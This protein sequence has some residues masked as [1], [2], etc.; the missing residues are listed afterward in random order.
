MKVMR[1]TTV[2]N[3]GG[4]EKNFELH[5]KYHTKS[6]YDLVFVALR[7]GGITESLLK[8]WGYPVFVLNQ[9]GKTPSIHTIWALVKLFRTE[10]PD[11][12]HTSGAEANFHGLIAA[13][14]AG[15]KVRIGEEVGIPSH[16]VLA[17]N[18][19]R[20]VFLS[21]HKVIAISK[22]VAKWLAEH[23]VPIE[24]INTVYYPIDIEESPK[25]INNSNHNFTVIC[26][27]RLETVKNLPRLIDAIMTLRE[28]LPERNVVLSLVGEGTQRKMLEYYAVEKG[29]QEFVTF[30]GYQTNPKQFLAQADLFV[31]PSLFEG[32]G[33]A[34]IEAIQCGLPVVVSNS[35][36]MIEYI[37]DC[38]N[39]FVI[40]PHNQQE[41]IDIMEYAITMSDD[42]RVRITS[43]AAHTV[44][45][46]F[47]PTM[48]EAALMK[49]YK[50]H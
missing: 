34:C 8:G 28:R 21:A 35:G 11:V 43:A 10:K 19:F 1:I 14:L 29:L 38:E 7:T 33:L 4:V 44:Q 3:Y 2:L 48:Y 50:L 20:L 23:E 17:K 13:W 47:S 15:V 37:N 25:K 26:V 24:K 12:V 39:G 22:A 41:L 42:E 9:Q 6:D 40:D 36:G 30:H 31:L 27:C 49:V 46:L 5:G 18:I 32:F 16:S 45:G